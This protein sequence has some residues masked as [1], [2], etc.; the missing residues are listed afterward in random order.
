MEQPRDG[1]IQDRIAQKL[2]ALI[3]VGRKA[4]VRQRL[5]EQLR[6]GEIMLQARLQCQ[7]ART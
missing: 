4:A 6:V 5:L 1:Q 7:Q 3:M 2:D